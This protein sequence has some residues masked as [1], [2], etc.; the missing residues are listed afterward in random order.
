MI[1]TVNIDV[2][3]KPP[4]EVAQQISEPFFMNGISFIPEFHENGYKTYNAIL[5]NLKLN[6]LHDRLTIKNSW[7]K[8][9]KGNNYSDYPLSEIEQTLCKLENKIGLS[10]EDAKI[11]RLAYGCVIKENPNLNYPNWLYLKT[12]PA[13]PMFSGTKTYGSFFNMID[14]RFKGYD[15]RFEVLKHNRID[16]N[17]DYF[18]IEKE[19]K[20][21]RHLKVRKEPI[22]INTTKDL[23]NKDIL[24]QLGLDL[25]NT[26]RKIEMK[27]IMNLEQ[28]DIK[29]LAKLAMM[30]NSDI[31]DVL[32][33]KHN[34]SYKRYKERFKELSNELN[35][36]Y[37]SSVE[38]KLANKINELING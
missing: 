36:D 7:H 9:Y 21:M 3:I 38:V 13:R 24:N 6:I 11:T 1:D 8:Y 14:Y 4:I 29:D 17:E 16:L 34:K 19:V 30:Q 2:I 26:Y 25:L 33:R 27:Q 32:K 23:F 37:Y 22:N 12:N 10:I 20:Y 28:I 35:G 18:R 15:K 5:D 31:R